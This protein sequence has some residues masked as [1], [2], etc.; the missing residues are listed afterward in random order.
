MS[1]SGRGGL[2]LGRLGLLLEVQ[3][4]VREGLEKGRLGEV[5]A[6]G[7]KG[8]Q[9]AVDRNVTRVEAAKLLGVSVRQVQRL[10]SKK[11]LKR[12]ENLGAVVVYRRGD[13]LRLARQRGKEA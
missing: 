2:G 11:L 5:I 10:E 13:V 3:G 12:C 8:H 6:E 9:D 7:V 1:H 4:V